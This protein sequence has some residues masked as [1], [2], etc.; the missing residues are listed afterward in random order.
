MRRCNLL[1]PSQEDMLEILNNPEKLINP[2]A[3]FSSKEEI[4]NLMFGYSPEQLVDKTFTVNVENFLEKY[5][6]DG[7]LSKKPDNV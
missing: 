5:Y 1:H 6:H 7:Y 2:F 3:G 4:Q